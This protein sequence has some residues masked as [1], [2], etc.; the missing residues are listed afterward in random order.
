L[1]ARDPRDVIITF[2]KAVC[3]PTPEAE[4]GGAEIEKARQA[5]SKKLHMTD[6]DW[7]DAV[8][9]AKSDYRNERFEYST[10][11]LAAFT[12]IDQWKAL[13][14]AFSRPGGNAPFHD[15]SYIADALESR[16]S[17]VGR[18]A[19][20]EACLGLGSQSVTSIPHV[21]WPLCQGDT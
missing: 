13:S 6:A 7:G 10:K 3:A 14:D 12:P 8:A 1:S 17:A 18:F 19:Y 20:I 9:Y 4:A 2:A 21:T 11:D 5:W 15:P 16:L